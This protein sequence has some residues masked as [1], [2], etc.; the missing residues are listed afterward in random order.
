MLKRQARHSTKARTRDDGGLGYEVGYAK[1]PRH[2]RFKPGQS[3]NP[4][5]QPRGSR[6]L[7]TIIEDALDET[8][9]IREGGRIRRLPKREAL[10]R[11]LVNGALMKDAKSLQAL[12]AMM[13]ATGSISETLESDPPQELSPEDEKLI[14][15]FLRRNGGGS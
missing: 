3:G 6:N 5:G 10:V 12:L 1:P 11:T 7:K 15:D 14:A 2:T 4:K 13:R 9:T 8:V